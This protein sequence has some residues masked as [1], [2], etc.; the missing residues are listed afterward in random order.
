MQSNSTVRKN[1]TL[2]EFSTD[3][4]SESDPQGFRLRNEK[5][6]RQYTIHYYNAHQ[7][8]LDNY[9]IPEFGDYLI[10]AINDVMIEDWIITLSSCKNSDEE[11]ADDSKNKVLICFRIILQEAVRQ[12]IIA[13]NPAKD[14]SLITVRSK[15]RAPFTDIELFRMFPKEESELLRIWGTR[16]WA[17]Y[18]LIM[19]DTGFRPG[20]VAALTEQCYN[21]ALHGLYTERSIDFSTRE[22][23]ERI[24]TTNKGKSYKV[25]IL[26]NQTV[27]QL[28]KLLVELNYEPESLFLRINN[29]PIIPAV[30]NKHLKSS[31]KKTDVDRKGGL[32]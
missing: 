29:R 7:S 23:L 21:P 24:K 32:L 19:R 8:R 5:R 27:E 26:T 11:L 3:F 16:T 10:S 17:V 6:N 4:F 9:I 22:I 12:R 25:G 31:L 28:D 20:E 2:K 18:F 14:I 30:A 1:I 15:S 13:K